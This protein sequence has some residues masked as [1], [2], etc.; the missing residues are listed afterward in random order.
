MDFK[1]MKT[2]FG[3]ALLA[4]AILALPNR[5]S[6]QQMSPT[7]FDEV[8]NAFGNVLNDVPPDIHEI[9]VSI[10]G[11]LEEGPAIVSAVINTDPAITLYKVA[12]ASI[13]Y[14]AGDERGKAE[15]TLADPQKNIWKGEIP[16]MKSGVLVKYGIMAEDEVGN[17]VVQLINSEKPFPIEA[18]L[19]SE[20]EDL[21]G[22]LDIVKTALASDGENLDF[23]IYYRKQFMWST[24]GGASITALGFYPEDV[25]F[26]PSHSSIENTHAFAA[27]IPFADV[28]GI[29]RIEE[30]GKSGGIPI[31]ISGKGSKVCGKT[32]ISNMTDKPYRGLK[33]YAATASFD[34]SNNIL[35]FGDSSPYAL[36]YF[37]GNHF[38][39][40]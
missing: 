37:S 25:R 15:M 6:A 7:I 20:D 23:C 4:L 34:T 38:I 28:K 11:P 24:A 10:P 30:L 5:P 13:Y 2:I 14:E 29:M 18:L 27:Y 36:V 31:D 33:V 19:D 22:S 1:N 40:R 9:S 8:P 35:N 26:V 3:G 32:P 39:F 21:D 12:K 17:S 16:R